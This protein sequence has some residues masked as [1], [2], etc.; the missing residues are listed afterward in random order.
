[1]KEAI[2]DLFVLIATWIVVGFV[3]STI[4]AVLVVYVLWLIKLLKGGIF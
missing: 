3:A 4:G 2:T 1:M